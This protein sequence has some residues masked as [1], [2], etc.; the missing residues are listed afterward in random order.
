[1]ERN[2]VR[3]AA[4]LREMADLGRRIGEQAS[5]LARLTTE[6]HSGSIQATSPP[7]PRKAPTSPHERTI[8]TAVHRPAKA[9]LASEAKKRH[10]SRSRPTVVPRRLPKSLLSRRRRSL[11]IGPGL[12]SG[13]VH[14]IVLL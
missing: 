5:E 9:K 14:L 6:R 1:M 10:G 7:T 4:V 2:D 3:V 12:V 8:R 13:V 11:V